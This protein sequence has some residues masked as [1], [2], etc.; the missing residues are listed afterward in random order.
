MS[1]TLRTTLGLLLVILTVGLVNERGRTVGLAVS[2]EQANENANSVAG[3]LRH[4]RHFRR[5]SIPDSGLYL[6]G[7]DA[8]TQTRYQADRM[9]DGLYYS[10][11]TRCQV[12]P[13]NF[14]AIREL[15][16]ISS[17]DFDVVAF[18]L[19][20]SLP[21]L[22]EYADR[23]E[24]GIPILQAPTGA[25]TELT[26]RFGTPFTLVVSDGCVVAGMSGTY[27]ADQL[28][29]LRFYATRERESGG[30]PGWLRSIDDC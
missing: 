7:V 24:L 30:G 29:Q 25:I 14:D 11:W 27:D 21:E 19:D 17:A 1:A 3:E 26:P 6:S 20:D 22:V 10:L 16:E 9:R 15:D 2:L 23:F 18:S 4:L 12:C 8:E 28:E 13:Q 5:S